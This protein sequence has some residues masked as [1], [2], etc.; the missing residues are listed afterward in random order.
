MW[1]PKSKPMK[2]K[3]IYLLLFTALL[4]CKTPKPQ[5]PKVNVSP[6]EIITSPI[7]IVVNPM[8]VWGAFEGELGGVRLF[9]GNGKELAKGI[10]LRSGP[11]VFTTTLEFDPRD[12]AQ[13]LL[14]LQHQPEGDYIDPP[15]MLSLEIPIRFKP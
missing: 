12:S 1:A 15:E 5:L 3:I 14:V 6:Q 9:D 2:L 13:G 10:L 8:G 11:I 7:E 4:S